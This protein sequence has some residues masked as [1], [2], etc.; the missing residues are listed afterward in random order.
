[1][2]DGTQNPL[3]EADPKSLD[4]YFS[5][6]PIDMKDSDIQVIVEELRRQRA[7]WAE[8]EAKAASGEKAKRAPAA[9]KAAKASIT[10]M[11]I[12]ALADLLGEG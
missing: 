6:D 8:N 4:Y 11:D 1:M 9:P 7:T 12:N 5:M 10:S 3:E 2:S